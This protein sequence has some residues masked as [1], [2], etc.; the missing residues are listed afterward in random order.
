MNFQIQDTGNPPHRCFC[1]TAK[2][3]VGPLVVLYQLVLAP[4]SEPWWSVKCSYWNCYWCSEI[5]F[6]GSDDDEMNSIVTSGDDSQR[7]T[8]RDR[9]F[10]PDDFD[11]D[12]NDKGDRLAKRTDD[13]LLNDTS[14]VRGVT[15]PADLH[16]HT[17]LNIIRLEKSTEK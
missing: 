7:Y 14:S 2:S 9:T 4:W 1:I 10:N 16:K 13:R 17:K 12:G 6:L 11:S 3:I 15:R 5:H 8:C